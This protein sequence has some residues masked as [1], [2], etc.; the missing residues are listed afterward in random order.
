M[1]R[2]EKSIKTDY[3]IFFCML[4]FISSINYSKDYKGAEYRTKEA[5]TYGRFEAR[6]KSAQCEGILASLFTYFDGTSTDPWSTAKWNEIDIEILGRYT[7]EVQFNTISPGQVNHVRSNY[8]PFNPALDFHTYAIEWTPEYVAWFIDEKEVYRQTGD[9]VK[10]L[11]HA[12]KFMMNIWN[13]VY[14]NWA[15]KWD[16]SV[17]PAF[18]YYDWASYYA[19][20]PNSG[21]YGT[22]NNF[23]LS[24]RD[25]FDLWD[26]SRWEKASHTFDGNNCDFIPD[27]AV[28]KNGMLILCLTDNSNTGYTDNKAPSLMLVRETYGN[29]NAYFSEE[30]DSVSAKDKSNYIIP[31]ATVDNAELLKDK[32]TVQLKVSNY[33]FSKGY[34]L[35]IQNIKDTFHPSNSASLQSKPIKKSNPLSFPIKINV[36]GNKAL[37]FLSDMEWDDNAEYG[38]MDGDASEY[39]ASLQINGTT[40]DSIFRYERTGIVAYKVRVPN[41]IYNLKLM[42]A[43]KYFNQ[44]NARVF[45]IYA[46]SDSLQDIDVYKTVKKN[47]AYEISIKNIN[48][49]DEVLDIY[50]AAEIDRAILDGITIDQIQTGL[51]EYQHIIPEIFKVQQNYP[52]PFNGMTTIN[53]FLG[54]SETAIFSV[55]DILG[56]KIYSKDLGLKG[57]GKNYL[58]WNAVSNNNIPLSS[59]VYF[60]SIKTK[61]NFQVKKMVLLN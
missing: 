22:D 31:G 28:F 25:N 49:T 52:N 9:F 46:E 10:A 36:G 47:S 59:G 1:H 38:Y 11:T 17:L 6:Y 27:N 50:F 35:I 15:G 61:D 44:N 33:D 45:D 34:N 57:K 3:T 40:Q 12:Q 30:I 7:N 37:G 16:P 13:P 20:T 23:R 26:Q 21:N 48:V 58:T 19:Y 8:T 14:D 55:Y 32:K 39:P 5:Y 2:K 53:F 4:L 54:R 41:G 29:I 42:M 18:A 56:N 43:E 60:Y 51:N 24:W